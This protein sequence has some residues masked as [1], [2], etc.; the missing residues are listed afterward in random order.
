MASQSTEILERGYENSGA[1]SERSLP[2]PI[3]R[4]WGGFALA[5]IEAICVFF[6]AASKAGLVLLA[7]NITG[8]V[9]AKFLHQD[10]LR[11]PL[12]LLAA[13]GS[14][15]NLY[16]LWN[17]QRLRNAPAAAWRKKPLARH[18]QLRIQVILWLSL[19]TLVLVG[20]EVYF[21][22]LLHQSII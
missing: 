14:V 7:V 3:T 11:I 13:S 8:S 6:I 17:A 15:F 16:L 20:G 22:R 10:I 19:A 5:A 1:I 2:V 18:E 4:A 12:L 21:H 9:V